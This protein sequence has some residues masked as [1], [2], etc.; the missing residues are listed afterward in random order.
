MPSTLGSYDLDGSLIRIQDQETF[1]PEVV[2]H[3]PRMT[4]VRCETKAGL[5]FINMDAEAPPL[6]ERLGLP[7]GYLEQYRMDKMHVV[8]HV[9]A[10]WGA[11]WKNGVDAFY[12]T[13]H[14][15]AIHPQT[16]GVM[17][18]IGT[19]YDLYPHGCQRM[20]V[21]IGRKSPRAPDQDEVDESLRY[22]MASEGMDA[23]AYRR[24]RDGRAGGDCA[25]QTAARQRPWGSTTNTSP[26]AS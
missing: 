25:A 10:E 21:P 12:E 22:M 5:V 17:A 20:I 16:Q 6:A 19:Q 8:R 4:P 23:D 1:K 9:V 18:D 26:T 13:Y 24:L 3:G 14:L 7:D 2:A 11:N 15:H